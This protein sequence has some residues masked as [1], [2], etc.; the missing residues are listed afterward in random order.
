M[1]FPFAPSTVV[2]NST[3]IIREA[4]NETYPVE[5]YPI[6]SGHYIVM[7]MTISPFTQRYQIVY[8]GVSNAKDIPQEEIEKR[9][10]SSALVILT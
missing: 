5:F 7:N 3:G 4:D 9:V 1:S 6:C 2:D 8:L 10:S